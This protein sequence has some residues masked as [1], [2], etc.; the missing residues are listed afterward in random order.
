MDKP[1]PWTPDYIVKACNAYP[2]LVKALKAA[3]RLCDNINEF[4]QVTDQVFYD[5]A[6]DAIRA[7]LS[8]DNAP[9]DPHHGGKIWNP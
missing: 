1:L 9:T 7:A 8:Y 5:A 2:E 3:K 6:E 4:G